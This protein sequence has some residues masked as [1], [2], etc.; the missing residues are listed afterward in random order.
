MFDSLTISAL[1]VAVVV[2]Y[3]VYRAYH[4]CRRC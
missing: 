1:L 3:V 2:A 4:R